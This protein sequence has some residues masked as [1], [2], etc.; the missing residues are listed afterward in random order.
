MISGRVRLAGHFV[1]QMR[2]GD[3]NAALLEEKERL[4]AVSMRENQFHTSQLHVTREHGYPRI[5]SRNEDAIPKIVVRVIDLH[6]RLPAINRFAGDNRV[7]CPGSTT[8]RGDGA[9]AMRSFSSRHS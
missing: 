2:A 3:M 1:P 6:L 4:G 9:D 7:A 8:A 5:A